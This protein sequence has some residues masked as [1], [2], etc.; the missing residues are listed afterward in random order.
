MEAHISSYDKL[1][2]F[3]LEI[4]GFHM[5]INIKIFWKKNRQLQLEK[6]SAYFW[7]IPPPL[8]QIHGGPQ[9]SRFSVLL[10]TQ[11]LFLEVPGCRAENPDGLWS[12]QDLCGHPSFRGRHGKLCILRCA[13]SV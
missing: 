13:R 4:P 11:L 1:F 6:I 8:D 5:Q 7:V 9:S 12:S 3:V 2:Q 10:G